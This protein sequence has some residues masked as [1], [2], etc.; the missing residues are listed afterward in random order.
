MS[1]DKY[2][3]ALSFSD[4]Y[5]QSHVRRWHTERVS[6]EQSLAEHSHRVAFVA[7]KMLYDY[8]ASVQAD[9]LLGGTLPYKAVP[10]LDRVEL[11][12]HRYAMIHDVV[13]SENSDVP[14]HIKAALRDDHGV[15]LNPIMHRM[16]WERRGF[17][18]DDY[19]VDPLVKA[20]VSLADTVDGMT[21]AHF[22]IPPGAVR[23]QV[24]KDWGKAFHSKLNKFEPLFGRKFLFKVVS[25]YYD[26]ALHLDPAW[27]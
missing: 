16:Y 23:D 11:G 4:F 17:G 21:F 14:S 3:A 25:D 24:L 7:V 2:L 19:D 15:D 9:N 6:R 26:S 5:A 13:E 10:E 18:G 1:G 27:A 22:H 20:L 12:I 8:V